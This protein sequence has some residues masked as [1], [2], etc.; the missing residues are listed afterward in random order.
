MTTPT[1][2]IQWS[3]LKPLQIER[4]IGEAFGIPPRNQ[5]WILSTDGGESCWRGG[6]KS[7]EEA[8]RYFK[9]HDEKYP[10]SWTKGSTAHLWTFPPNFTQNMTDAWMLVQK[11]KSKGWTFQL[12]SSERNQWGA[13]FSKLSVEG[14]QRHRSPCVAICIA[15][16]RAKGLEVEV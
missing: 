16:L 4:L 6:F 15:A 7:K 9:E 12:T 1:N 10:E 2:K 5:E 8:E 11:L 13:R 14:W 3:K